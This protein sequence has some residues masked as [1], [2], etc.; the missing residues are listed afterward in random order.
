[1]VA[2]RTAAA[3]AVDEGATMTSERTGPARVDTVAVV[4]AGLLVLLT[5]GV[6]LEVT[7]TRAE[8]VC[9][10]A[11]ADGPGTVGTVA[12]D[13]SWRPVGIRCSWDDGS[14]TSLWWGTA[15]R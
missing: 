8:D 10:Q 6:Y 14:R 7:W 2:R 3:L 9:A 5:G 1:M 15:Q 4:M 11:V 13:W 12:V